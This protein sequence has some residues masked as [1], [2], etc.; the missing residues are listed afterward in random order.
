MNTTYFQECTNQKPTVFIH[1]QDPHLLQNK[2]EK[3]WIYSR[4][5]SAY[6]NNISNENPSNSSQHNPK[7]ATDLLSPVSDSDCVDCKISSVEQVMSCVPWWYCNISSSSA[8]SKCS[9]SVT[10]AILL[11]LLTLDLSVQFRLFRMEGVNNFLTRQLWRWWGWDDE[12]DWWTWL[13]E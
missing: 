11:T 7:S 5:A 10:C 2:T 4:S 8:R 3:H 9:K 12:D 1:N 6:T 13:S